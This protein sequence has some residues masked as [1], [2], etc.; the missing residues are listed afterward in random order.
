MWLT[1][2]AISRPVVTAMLFI[3]LAVF[4]T[5][6]FFKLGRSQ[7]P[8]NTAFPVVIVQ[9]NYP[10]ASPDEMTKLIIKPIE[11][12][13]D[14]I[15]D[16][17]QITATAQES[18]ASVVVQFN[19][20]TDLN[21]AAINIQRAV[22]A[23]RVYMPNDLDPPYVFKNGSTQPLLDLAVS[24]N[25][26]SPAQLSDVVDN[27]LKPVLKAIPNIQTVDVYGE[28]TREFHVYPNP[29]GLLA[30]N[31]TLSDIFS[32]ISQNNANL[33]G[34]MLAQPTREVSVSVH[35]DI[36]SA[37]DLAGI[38]LPIPG[39]ASRTL[40]I[41]D[42][43]TTDDGHVTQRYISKYNGQPRL[44][45]SLGRTITSDE[46]SATAIARARLVEI[47]KQFPQLSFHEI[48]APADYTNDSLNG[49][50]QSLIE[51]IILTAIVMM[52]FLHA[53]R[54]AAVVLIAIPSSI[55]STFIVMQIFGF[56]LDMMSLMGLS[57]IIGILVDDSIVVLE[58]ITRHRDLG[59]SADEATIN[60]RNEIGGAAVAITMVDVVVFL[61]IAFLP[62]IVGRYLMEFGA[63]VVIATIFSLFV[64]FTLTPLLAAKWSVKKRELGL[65]GWLEPLKDW[66]LS[67]ALIL[68]AIGMFFVPWSYG[69]II[70]IILAAL[71]VL[72][73]IVARYDAILNFYHRKALPAA[74]R[75]GYLV[76]FVCTLLTI[77]SVLLIAGGKVAAI[78]D[79]MIILVLTI[80]LLVSPLT[81]RLDRRGYLRATQYTEGII[82]V[83][84]VLYS[85][86]LAL[87]GARERGGN[88]GH[89]RFVWFAAPMNIFKF[90][91]R[92]SAHMLSNRRVLAATFALPVTLALLMPLLGKI[93]FEF[94]PPTQ[95]GA[96]AMTLTYPPGTPIALT[97]K[98]TDDLSTQIMKIPGIETVSSTVG[99]KPSGHGSSIGG[100]YATL[101]AQT[102][103]AQRGNT[104]AIIE[105]VRG[106]K[107]YAPGGDFQ[108]SSD[109]G[110][111]SGAQIFYSLTGPDAAINGAAEKVANY[112]RAIPGSVNVQT[113]AEN[114][115]PRLNVDI[116]RAQCAVLGVSPGAAASAARLAIDGA[117][118]TK[119]RTDTGLVDV[120]VEFPKAL[121][122]DESTIQNV[123]VRASDGSLVPVG[124]VATFTWTTAPTRIERL[125][126]QR[127]VNVYGGTL[128]GFA[129]G[130]VVGP[131]E[132]ALHQP[133]FLPPGVALKAQGD[134]EFMMQTIS[135]M[136]IALLV[137][138]MLVYMLMVILY[139]SFVEP[140]IVMFSVPVAIVGALMGLGVAHLINPQGAQSLNLISMIGI[141]MLFGLVSKNGI[142]LVDY[143]NTLCKRG[144]RVREAVLEAAATRFRPIVMT[145]S[146]MVFGMLPLALGFAEGAEWRQSMGT[147]I[148]GGLLSSLILTLFLVPMI[149]NTWLGF[150]QRLADRKAVQAEQMPV[151]AN[152]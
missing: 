40:R 71:V 101:N 4:G 44:Y 69:R 1:R 36:N 80:G 93:A 18:S 57:L 50:W 134:T 52:L 51:G 133:G 91:L 59:E 85:H 95:T 60:G 28:Q 76:G 22:D 77:N 120:R 144:M 150:A 147:V 33:P 117:V 110:G 6:S 43:A 75:H 26:L 58:N 12:Q 100:N 79:V 92:S 16:V 125:N 46:I 24:S 136:G 41:G 20:G 30:V 104:N 64:S 27:R 39:N 74:L 151:F 119:V 140:L 113:S 83:M 70:G 42:V 102:T 34:G 62:G 123:R 129:L 7:D 23:A 105:K 84:G 9:A 86:V 2:F 115:A 149:Y 66:R 128:P 54:N 143:S 37:S 126:R 78:F 109:G 38:A 122:A 88:N 25:E 97:S 112:L 103:T 90:V 3:A 63:V 137:S 56:H 21:L 61:P 148:I 31:G 94:V 99:R 35:A 139:G 132:T 118:A 32:A 53:W 13:L 81:R 19:L 72:N 108:V 5:I 142:L 98:Y 17:D 114:G 135:N 48:D 11:D 145:T 68:V 14:G 82:S 29:A 131:L 45:V 65:P 146:A 96:I 67:G 116:N 73:A 111:G 138:F 47:E 121:R 107:S 152:V 55:F 10:G 141:I 127:V 89:G 15:D 130:S 49:V 8:P 87:V 124:D 106:L